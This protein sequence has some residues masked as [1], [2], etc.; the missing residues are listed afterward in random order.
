MGLFRI[1]EKFSLYGCQKQPSNINSATSVP[2]FITLGIG[3]GM[4]VIG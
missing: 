4:K 1:E 2:L 3:N